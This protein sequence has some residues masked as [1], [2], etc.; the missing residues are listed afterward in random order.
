MNIFI[1]KKMS[2]VNLFKGDNILEE[3]KYG[4]IFITFFC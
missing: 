2:V 1:K 4:M 3:A